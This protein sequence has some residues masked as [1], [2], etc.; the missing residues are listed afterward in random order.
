MDPLGFSLENFDV[1]G[2]WRMQ[3]E[4]GSID[5][6]A[7]LVSGQTFSGPQGL[8][9]V[10]LIRQDEFVSATV[11]RLL[12]YA[13]GRELDTRDQPTIR[14][15]MRNTEPGGYRFED[16]IVSIVKSVPFRMRQTQNEPKGT[17]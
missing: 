17:L 2:R 5:A 7:K 1:I 12:T 13:L 6:S 9:Q 4:G 16:L 3:D 15:I 14:L 10:L 8:R 11:A